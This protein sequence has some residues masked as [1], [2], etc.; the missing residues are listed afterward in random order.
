MIDINIALPYTFSK[1]KLETVYSAPD[2]L[3]DQLFQSPP[4]SVLYRAILQVNHFLI[5][6]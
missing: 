3:F 4:P 2:Y 1:E 5:N 6:L